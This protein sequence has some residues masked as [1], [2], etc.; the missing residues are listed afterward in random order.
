MTER[1]LRILLTAVIIIVAVFM[2]VYSWT[3]LPA[4]VATQPAGFQTGAPSIPK[5]IA[6]ALPTMFMVI[7]GYL[8]QRET[9]LYLGSL[10]GV[11]LHIAFW[12]T[13]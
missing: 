12:V 1:T 5:F 11:A 4:V 6:V 2:A 3:I 7:F 8:G 13:N 9:K 10:I